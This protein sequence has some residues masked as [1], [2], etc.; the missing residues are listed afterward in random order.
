MV[1]S[2]ALGRFGANAR[3]VAPLLQHRAVRSALVSVVSVIVAQ[4]TLTFAFG[5]LHWGAVAANV[6]ATAVATVPSYSLNRAW[7]WG[8]R[9]RSHLLRRSFR[10]GG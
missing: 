4:V 9:G 2:A 10:S 6:L 8:R 1:S 7:V 3:L 5:V